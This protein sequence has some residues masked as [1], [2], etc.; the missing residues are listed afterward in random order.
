M[1][2]V[3]CDGEKRTP[4]A[5][6]GQKTLVLSPWGRWGVNQRS[7]RLWRYGLEKEADVTGSLLHGT[8]R[9]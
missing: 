6:A 5:S 2:L 9:P 3:P 8:E 1:R 7:I 4:R